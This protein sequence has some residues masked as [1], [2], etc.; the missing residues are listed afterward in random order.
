M[1][2]E[3][4]KIAALGTIGLPFVW[5]N[6]GFEFET[7]VLVVTL[8]SILTMDREILYEYMLRRKYVDFL[9]GRFIWI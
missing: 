1:D 7:S 8:H 2:E 5:I 3:M 4:F 9:N 6:G